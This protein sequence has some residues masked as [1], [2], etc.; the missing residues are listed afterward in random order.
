MILVL[1]LLIFL[2][3]RVAQIYAGLEEKY[4]YAIMKPDEFWPIQEFKPDEF[5]KADDNYTP[6][7]FLTNMYTSNRVV[8]FYAVSKH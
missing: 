6:P 8:E 3:M 5:T 4:L 1:S 2:L 7:A